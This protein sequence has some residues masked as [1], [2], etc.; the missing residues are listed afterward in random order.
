MT[1]SHAAYCRAIEAFDKPNKSYRIKH[2]VMTT[3]EMRRRH[4]EIILGDAYTAERGR[5]RPNTPQAKI[6]Y[7]DWHQEAIH[8]WHMNKVIISE[9]RYSFEPHRGDGQR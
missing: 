2:H 7:I 5:S 9:R 3:K 8:T 1:H 6:V 4:E